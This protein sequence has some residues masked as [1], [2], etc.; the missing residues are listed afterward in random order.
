MNEDANDSAAGSCLKVLWLW[1]GPT[2]V[3]PLI[4]AL[5]AMAWPVGVVISIMFLVIMGRSFATDSSGR[6]GVDTK[7]DT[8]RVVLYVVLQI[9]WIPLF[10]LGVLW[11]ICA[12]NGGASF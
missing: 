2:F 8:A 11:G 10:V 6:P 4:M 9:I 7:P 5:M 1:C 3:V 12:M